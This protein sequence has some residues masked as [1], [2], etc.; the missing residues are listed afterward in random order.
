MFTVKSCCHKLFVAIT[1]LTNESISMFCSLT[2]S[3]LL[4][5]WQPWF[6]NFSD[7]RFR[8]ASLFSNI[9][10]SIKHYWRLFHQRYVLRGEWSAGDIMIYSGS[11]WARWQEG[12]IMAAL[13][14]NII[15]NVTP[16]PGMYLIAQSPQQLSWSIW[17]CLEVLLPPFSNGC[18]SQRQKVY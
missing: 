7:H 14:K 6:L 8:A 17:L 18:L 1:T 10:W 13:Q 11:I 3:K 15:C 5:V 2:Y 12:E 9:L 16:G 4:E